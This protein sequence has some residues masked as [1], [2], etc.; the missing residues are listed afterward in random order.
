MKESINPCGGRGGG[1]GGGG[2]ATETLRM[3]IVGDGKVIEVAS[4]AAAVDC[5]ASAPS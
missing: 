1:G 3:G 5:E 4:A 2:E